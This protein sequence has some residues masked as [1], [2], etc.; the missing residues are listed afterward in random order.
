[1]FKL[2]AG[3][4]TTM[5]GAVAAVVAWLFRK[6]E[7]ESNKPTWRDDSLDEWR[8]ERDL[9]AERDR[10]ERATQAKT[11]TGR[12]EEQEEKQQHQ[13]IGG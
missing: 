9:N 12:A 2:L 13:R 6:P 5:L 3:G 8:K 7:D 11:S 10:K 4:L 1:M